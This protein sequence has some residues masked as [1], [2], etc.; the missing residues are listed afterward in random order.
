[1]TG[2]R[3]ELAIVDLRNRPDLLPTVMDWHAD[4]WGNI[5]SRAEIA[6]MYADSLCGQA[7]EFTLI[8]LA[9]ATPAGMASLRPADRFYNLHRH[10]TPWLD[11]VY[12]AR[13]HRRQGIATVL[14]RAVIER[15]RGLHL[16][17]LHLGADDEAAVRIYSQLDFVAM[18]RTAAYGD[19]PHIIMRRILS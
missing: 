8:G 15:A 19:P 12:V 9:G 18:E 4:A 2:G 5:R 11:S 6:A 17:A 10:L 3:L 14:C 7:G 16:A 1:M 13:D